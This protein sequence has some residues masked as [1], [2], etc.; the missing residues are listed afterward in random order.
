[1]VIGGHCISRLGGRG[2]GRV[3]GTDGVVELLRVRTLAATLHHQVDLDHLGS[4][5][6][7]GR[8]FSTVVPVIGL[9]VSAT[10]ATGHGRIIRGN[11]TD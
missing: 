11:H 9:L 10:A 1:M 7:I 3:V 6:R 4:I 5:D 2:L 8:R